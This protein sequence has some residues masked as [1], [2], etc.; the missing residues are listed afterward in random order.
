MLVKVYSKSPISHVFDINDGNAHVIKGTN[1]HII[2]AHTEPFCNEVEEMVFA[3]IQDKYKAHTRLFGG[4]DFAGNTLDA[5]IY[6]A[7]TE[8]E[9]LKK[10]VDTAEVIAD[11]NVIMK[12]KNVKAFKA[13]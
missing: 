10:A 7:K 4:K 11:E 13:D 9:A 5:Q 2:G 12:N 3:K 1:S 8:S 6:V